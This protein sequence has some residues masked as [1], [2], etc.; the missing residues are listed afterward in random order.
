M[1]D[2]EKKEWLWGV[3]DDITKGLKELMDKVTWWLND[4]LVKLWLKKKTETD[5]TVE[6]SKKEQIELKIW[7]EIEINTDYTD[8]VSWLEEIYD[9][10]IVEIIKENLKTQVLEDTTELTEV[11]KNIVD[12][13]EEAQENLEIIKENEEIETIIETIYSDDDIEEKYSINEIVLAYKVIKD[14]KEEWKED[15]EI[16]KEKILEKLEEDNK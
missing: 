12:I 7:V 5:E 10:D 11:D 2:I 8:L 13:V 9:D 1:S 16:T 3:L 6:G 4:L 14:W 15:E